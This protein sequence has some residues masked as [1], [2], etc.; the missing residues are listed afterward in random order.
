[1]TKVSISRDSWEVYYISPEQKVCDGD[2]TRDELKFMR[3]IES[4]WFTT[5]AILAEKHREYRGSKE[6]VNQ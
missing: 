3:E 2:F 6:K 4:L 5:Q 1:M